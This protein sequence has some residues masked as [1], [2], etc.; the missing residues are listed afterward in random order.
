MRK[1]YC[2]SMFLRKRDDT[3]NKGPS[4]VITAGTEPVTRRYI[5]KPIRE[6][7]VEKL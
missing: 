3:S 5:Y 4:E 6:T 1:E 7:S 2:I